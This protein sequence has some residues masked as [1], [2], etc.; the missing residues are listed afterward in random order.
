MPNKSSPTCRVRATFDP[1]QACVIMLVRALDPTALK[2]AMLDKAEVR[3]RGRI[4]MTLVV[5]KERM[6]EEGWGFY[7]GTKKPLADLVA[8]TMKRDAF[9]VATRMKVPCSLRHI[10][11]PIPF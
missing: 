2:W 5:Q 1:R 6:R 7:R 3:P 8:E 4:T 10:L 9:E 11:D